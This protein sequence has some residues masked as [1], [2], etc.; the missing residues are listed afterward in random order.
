MLTKVSDTSHI[1][2]IVESEVDVTPLLEIAV[3]P[4]ISIVPFYHNNKTGS[5]TELDIAF[6]LPS[7]ASSEDRLEIEGAQELI[8]PAS[9][10][11]I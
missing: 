7:S 9:T 2:R 4:A 10:R 5:L 11:Q 1:A 6:H 3:I 8:I